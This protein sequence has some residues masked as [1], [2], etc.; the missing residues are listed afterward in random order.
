MSFQTSTRDRL[1]G[2]SKNY[3][4]LRSFNLKLYRGSSTS[5]IPEPEQLFLPWFNYFLLLLLTLQLEASF[6]SSPSL[7]IK[8][9]RDSFG[10]T[11]LVKFTGNRIEEPFSA[12]TTFF[13]RKNFFVEQKKSKNFCRNSLLQQ[14]LCLFNVSHIFDQNKSNLLQF[15]S[16]KLKK[17][18]SYD[19]K[20]GWQMQCFFELF[21]IHLEYSLYSYFQFNSMPWQ[22][23][24][25]WKFP[26]VFFINY[27]PLLIYIENNCLFLWFARVEINK[28]SHPKTF[29]TEIDVS[30]H[31]VPKL[32]KKVKPSS[33]S[34]EESKQI[35]KWF[36]I[37]DDLKRSPKD[38][39]DADANR[40][41]SRVTKLPVDNDKK[42]LFLFVLFFTQ[43]VT[44][45]III[46]VESFHSRLFVKLCLQESN[47]LK[48]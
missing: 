23:W 21:G 38:N 37:K 45:L 15:Q 42:L 32:G 43:N 13:S 1:V 31:K 17:I 18:G 41:F 2:W 46:S 44:N 16:S 26:Y 24:K 36:Q 35:A 3:A 7:E 39:Y 48:A 22:Q 25:E 11:K 30:L 19:R 33:G 10:K 20:F 5:S 34:S 14:Q 29:P 6:E 28:F 27:L 12:Y 40:V 8:S 9:Y 47:I 4:N